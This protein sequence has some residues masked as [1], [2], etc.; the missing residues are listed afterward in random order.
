M[1]M[2][3]QRVDRIRQRRALAKLILDMDPGAPGVSEICGQQEGSMY[4]GHFACECNHPMF[5]SI[6]RAQRLLREGE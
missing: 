5:V 3:G 4:N 2:P 1:A 6:V